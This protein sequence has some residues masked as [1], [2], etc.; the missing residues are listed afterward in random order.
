MEETE[1]G[2]CVQGFKAGGWRK[3]KYGVAIVLSEE[4]ANCALAVTSNRLKAAPLLVSKSHAEEGRARGIVANSGNANAFTGREGLEDAER[5]CQLAAKELGLKAGDLI[6]ASTGI[7]GRR[8]DMR[9]IEEGI[10]DVSKNLKATGDASLEAAKALMTT[11][12]FPKMISV[13][14]AL[15]DGTEVEI[16]GIAK[17]AGMIAPD[18]ATM[19]CFL[20]TNA[21]VPQEKMKSILKEAVDQS[22]NLTVIDG[23]TSTNDMVVLLANG[24]AGNGDVDE[25]F[26]EGLNYV[27]RELAKMIA[28]NAEGATKFIEVTVRNAAS[29]G[30]AKRAAKAIAGSNLVKT[31][32]FGQD[33]N[34]GRIIAA[35][36]YSR[37][38]FNSDKMSLYL[39]EVCLV[40]NGK[41]LAYEGSKVLEEARESLKGNEVKIAVDL[42][43][44]TSKATAYGCDLTP[45]YVKINAEYTT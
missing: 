35:L 2:I 18:L 5:M 15:K 34:W 45:E 28:K 25:N 7:I 14:T 36:G 19:L 29:E 11:D 41:I 10:K 4:Q 44:G 6:V 43:M 13:K 31:A 17:G 42:A 16:G 26:Q 27:T 23:D 24:L 9:A 20:T 32:M 38:E 1:K 3:G 33:P 37:A 40:D 39:N 8:L 22:F 30:D 12:K 21:Y